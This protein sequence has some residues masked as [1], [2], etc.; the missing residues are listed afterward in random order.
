MRRLLDRAE[1]F[2]ASADIGIEAL[3]SACRPSIRAARRLYAEIGRVVE[4]NGFDSVSQ[5][6]IV[7]AQRKMALAAQ[8]FPRLR[9]SL[10]V[11]VLQGAEFLIEA[12][13]RLSQT[14]RPSEWALPDRLVW[15]ANVLSRP[16]R[17]ARPT[18]DSR[19]TSLRQ[20]PPA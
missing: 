19:R 8:S 6:A 15:A 11:P 13:A 10:R 12:A 2:Y 5:R 18:R 20:A 14:G 7:A 4:A 1:E 3:P 17:P 9:R 16:P